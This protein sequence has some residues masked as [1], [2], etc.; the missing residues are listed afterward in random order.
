LI[1]TGVGPTDY[2]GRG[3]LV[4]GRL[5]DRLRDAGFTPPDIDIVCLSHLHADHTGWVAHATGD[6]VFRNA[7]VY[8]GEADWNYFIAEG[9]SPALPGHVAHAL[10]TLADRGQV[11]LLDSQHTV[12]SG[13]TRMPAPGHTPGHSTY[14]AHHGRDRVMLLG[15]A[16]YCPHQLTNDDWAAMS[17]VD[18]RLAPQ[19]RARYIR[20]LEDSGGTALGC[21]FPEL[22]AGRAWAPAPRPD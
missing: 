14:L 20:D 17:D 22:A 18:P 16:M 10:H 19:T 15:D 12:V 6:P 4:G 9:A 8:L 5:L 21:H 2:A 7:R 13:L 1:D 11:E 3:M